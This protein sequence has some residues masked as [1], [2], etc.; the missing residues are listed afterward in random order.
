MLHQKLEFL[1]RLIRLESMVLCKILILKASQTLILV[2]GW[3]L[4]PKQTSMKYGS[5]SDR[6]QRNHFDGIVKNWGSLESLWD[7]F[8]YQSFKKQKLTEADMA[9]RI[10]M[11][12]WFCDT[13][14]D[15]PD[16]L[17]HVWFSDEAQFQLSGHVNS[18]NNVYWGTVPPEEVLQTPLHL[19]KCTAWVAISKHGLIVSYWFEDKKMRGLKRWIRNVMWQCWGSF[20]HHSDVA[21]V[22]IE[23]TSGS[24]KTGRAPLPSNHTLDWLR[25]RFQERLI[26][27]KCDV[28]WAPHSPDLNPPDFYLWGYLKDHVYQN[29]TQTTGELKAAIAAKIREIPREECMRVIENF[30][31]QLLVCLQRRGGHLEHILE[32]P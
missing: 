5:Q 8:S 22:L 11:C 27:R 19:V 13:I 24:S 20:G 12:E 30:A 31:L 23:M 28:E 26:S 16:F 3:V 18:K 17:D 1:T 9:K 7:V 32:R 25:E 21:E 10:A 15:N 29:N 2:G 6:V 14:E 4:R